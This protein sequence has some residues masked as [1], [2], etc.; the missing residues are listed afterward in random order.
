MYTIGSQEL[1]NHLLPY[2]GTN[3]DHF[4]HELLNFARSPY[5]ITGY[6]RH[7]VYDRRRLETEVVSSDSEE[8]LVPDIMPVAVR[9]ES[10]LVSEIR[11]D[12]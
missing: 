10:S 2:L 7:V 4:Q 9:E 6:D 12:Y 8:D 1:S 3:T 11:Y 5:D